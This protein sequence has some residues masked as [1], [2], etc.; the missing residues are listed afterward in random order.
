MARKKI[1]N[2]IK[3]FLVDE[4]IY[5]AKDEISLI[6]LEN[7]YNQYIIAYEEVKKNGQTI[8]QIDRYENKRVVINSSFMNY[9]QLQKELF[10]LIDSLYLSPKSRK[11]AK[12]E[13]KEENN[14]FINLLKDI[15]DLESEGE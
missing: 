15:N 5:T 12:V 8:E 13:M 3:Q 2:D 10:K 1:I 11:S 14:P 9:L 6:L 7:T 4:E